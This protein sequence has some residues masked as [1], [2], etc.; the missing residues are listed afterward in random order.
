MLKL[1]RWTRGAVRLAL[2]GFCAAV[3]L[4]LFTLLISP[5]LPDS[6]QIAYATGYVTRFS[7]RAYDVKTGIT[8]SLLEN[9]ASDYLAWSPLNGPWVYVQ[10]LLN[11]THI[12][13]ISRDGR[14]ARLLIDWDSFNLTP[15]LSPD[16]TRMLFQSNQEGDAELYIMQLADGR[17]TQITANDS[18]DGDPAWSPDGT[19]IVF[20]SNRD[21]INDLYIMQADGT[22]LRRL[23]FNQ[24]WKERPSWSPDGGRIAFS[25]YRRNN[26]EIHVV[27]VSGENYR[28]LT[29]SPSRDYRP[30]WSPDG[31]RIVFE[32]NRERGQNRI[33]IMDADGRNVHRLS[34]VPNYSFSPV[35]WW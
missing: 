14:E 6:G 29:D 31:R 8:A 19:R 20:R 25:A 32:S 30:G 23:T 13:S 34:S 33:F 12:Y 24:L 28:A 1:L 15:S 9:V 7:V 18:Y 27:D 21:G 22:G 5:A 26:W 16:G 2:A 3:S 35:W 4:V 11:S 17:V 10:F